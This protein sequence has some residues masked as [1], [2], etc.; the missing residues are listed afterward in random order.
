MGT[1]QNK[2]YF[3]TLPPYSDD[4]GKAVVQQVDAWY[5]TLAGGWHVYQRAKRVFQLVYGLPSSAS[6]FDVSVVGR[7]G[8]SGELSQVH[9]NALGNFVHRMVTLV[10]ARLPNVKPITTNTDPSSQE[11]AM[12]AEAV[13]AFERRKANLPEMH[14]DVVSSAFITML[15]WHVVRFNPRGGGKWEAGGIPL[16][17]QTPAG[18]SPMDGK[19]P[20]MNGLANGVPP[21]PMTAPTY[22]GEVEHKSYAMWDVIWNA[23]TRSQKRNWII[24]KDYV[25]KFELADKNPKFADQIVNLPPDHEKVREHWRVTGQDTFESEEVPLYTLFHVDRQGLVPGGM[26]G[27]EAEVVGSGL[28]LTD[29]DGIYGDMLPG[30]PLSPARMVGTVVPHSPVADMVSPQIVL[31]MLAS[32][33][34]TNMANGSVANYAITNAS[35]FEVEKA[36]DG[37]NIFELSGEN[38]GMQQL[39]GLESPKEAYKLFDVV[40]NLFQ[41]LSGIGDVSM[42]RMTAGMPA[43]L[44]ALLDA[45]TQEFANVFQANAYT[46][47]QQ[48]YERILFVYQKCIKV[49]RDLEVLVGQGRSYL[50]KGF[51]GDKLGGVSRV[52]LEQSNPIWDSTAG[53]LQLL[54]MVQKPELMQN[55]ELR[56]LVFTVIRTGRL[57]DYADPQEEQQRLMQYENE[58]LRRG[59]NPIVRTD[60]PHLL[61]I[62]SVID[63]VLNTPE[64]RAAPKI[65]QA[66][67]QHLLGHLEGITAHALARQPQVNPMTG[68][69]VIGPDGQPMTSLVMGM[70][71]P[72]QVALLA[73]TGQA[74]DFQQIM[75]LLPAPAS[76]APPSGPAEPGSGAPGPAT[77]PGPSGPPPHGGGP[78]PNAPPGGPGKLPPLPPMPKDP[79]TGQRAAPPPQPI[80][81]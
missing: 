37:G 68:Q 75:S 50:H 40:L 77:H 56:R 76:P 36:P 66:A 6:P 59:E 8:K 58:A 29:G 5:K 33:M 79:T 80:T 3:A 2:P 28:V 31:N 13:F 64:A 30:V 11:Q 16:P 43:S 22:L 62:R 65:Q 71:L 20:L 7:T 1:P 52:E 15:G 44:A 81:P 72:D 49:P 35:D 19:P 60:D 12:L 46:H 26:K 24:T 23:T 4:F 67:N 57:D 10:S 51:T 54:E 63:N 53:K 39:P 41:M 27:R 74:G 17:G 25:N 61:H 48:V 42:G 21:A 47:V 32:S 78:P 14:R 73:A 45:K 34:T 70:P 9:W 69:P 55:P 18:P 38:A